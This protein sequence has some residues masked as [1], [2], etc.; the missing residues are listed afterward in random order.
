VEHAGVDTGR[1]R[2]TRPARSS[3]TTSSWPVRAR[4]GRRGDCAALHPDAFK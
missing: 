1:P 2:S 4:G 3:A